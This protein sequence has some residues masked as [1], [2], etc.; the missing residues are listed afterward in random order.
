MT[1]R[2][3]AP[4]GPMICVGISFASGS[5]MSQ[6][7][8]AIGC[9]NFLTFGPRLLLTASSFSFSS[10]LRAAFIEFCNLMDDHLDKY[11]IAEGGT[12]DGGKQTMKMRNKQVIWD[13]KGSKDGPNAL[14]GL[15]AAKMAPLPRQHALKPLPETAAASGS[16]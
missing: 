16:S 9:C 4:S 8:L 10:S 12:M 7:P 1:F 6:T 14:S 3:D 15:G 11:F 5:A 13:D 2:A